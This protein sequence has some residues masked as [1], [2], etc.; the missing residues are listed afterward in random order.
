MPRI[1]LLPWRLST[2]LLLIASLLLVSKQ[3]VFFRSTTDAASAPIAFR[4]SMRDRFGNERADGLIDYHWNQTKEQYDSEYVNPKRWTVDFD[5]CGT[6]PSPG[7]LSW[8]V[9]GQPLPQTTCSFSHDFTELKSYVVSLT[10]TTPDGQSNSA[11]ASVT[12][13]DILIV[14]IGDSFASG[15][16]NP[17]KTRQDPQGVKWIDARCHRSAWAGPARAALILEKADPKTAVTF[18]SFACTGAS[19][20]NGLLGAQ[21]RN[22]HAVPPQLDRLFEVVKRERI[23][24]LLVSIGGN[25]LN[26]STFVEK[27]ILLRHAETN[28]NAKEIVDTGL[29]DLPGSLGLVAERVSAPN[30]AAV[31]AV[32]ISEY[33]DLV[34]DETRDLCDHSVRLTDPLRQISEAESRWALDDVIK[35]LNGVIQKRATD[36]GWNYVSKILSEFSGDSDSGIAHGFCADDKRWVNTFSDSRRIQGDRRGTIHPNR[37]G[38]LWYAQRLVEELGSKL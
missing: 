31:S 10:V 20:T 6:V 34:R 36:F 28:A 23:D 3:R 38:H 5:A 12:L 2:L 32:F 18:I 11:R 29:R 21:D 17:D 37:E 27:A 13:K 16:G 7:E 30:H 9:D 25:D 4:W 35:P 33:P 14:S 22:G 1:T 8:D 24:A 19:I 26:F 15:E